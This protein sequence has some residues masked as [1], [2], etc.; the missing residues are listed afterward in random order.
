MTSTGAVLVVEDDVPVRMLLHLLLEDE[1]YSVVTAVDGFEAIDACT[2]ARPRVVILDL[3]LPEMDGEQVAA[4]L[5]D[6]Y[7]SDLPIIVVSGAHNGRQRSEQIG[8][9]GFLGKPFEVDDLL[10]AVAHVTV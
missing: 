1:G 9:A 7:G 2:H 10:D 6:L 4:E 8:P 5:H 3:D